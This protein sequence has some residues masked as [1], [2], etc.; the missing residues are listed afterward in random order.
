MTGTSYG[1]EGLSK[2]S[3][4]LVGFYEKYGVQAR[5]AYTKRDKYLQVA[6]GRNGLP[7]YFD[8]YGQLDASITYN[9][10]DHFSLSA[11][12]LNLNNAKE[13]TYQVIPSQTFSYALTGRRFLV[14]GRMKF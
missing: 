3:Y 9:I 1:L 10:N 11:N 7:T 12:A 5:V 13:F 2:N 14:G 4:S 8:G 6:Q